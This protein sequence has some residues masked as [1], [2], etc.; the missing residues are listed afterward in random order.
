MT[1][2]ELG[3]VAVSRAGHDKGR[4]FLIIGRADEAHVLLSDGCTR[5]LDCPKKKKLKHLHLEPSRADEIADRLS[6]GQP[7]LDADI[8]KA[9]T[10]LGYRNE[11]Q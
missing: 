4:A 2:P 8:R 6:G 5:K 1:E 9:L 10:R 11:N 3:V 7:L